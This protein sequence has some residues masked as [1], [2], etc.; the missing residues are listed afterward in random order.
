ME[1]N[2]RVEVAIRRINESDDLVA[3]TELLHRAYAE[4]ARMGFR[5]TAT[6]QSPEITKNR[7]R[8][9]TCLVAE[10]D[11]KTVGTVT[12]YSPE[13]TEHSEW[14]DRPEVSSFGQFGV[15]PSHQGRGIG[16]RLMDEVERLARE[17]GAEE[18]ACDTA[19][20]ATHLIELYGRRGY[21]LVG[22]VNW[23]DT[24]YVSVVLSKDLRSMT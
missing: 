15:D 17:S 9:G 7:C 14:Y 16:S 10:T 8:A 13:Q 1:P 23:R 24:N 2:E 3:L 19:E 4:L 5:Y 22:T 6:Y 20:G 21:R 12:Y 18:I 11:G